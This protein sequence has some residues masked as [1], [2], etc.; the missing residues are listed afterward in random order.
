MTGIRMAKVIIDLGNS[1]RPNWR[2]VTAIV[3]NPDGSKDLSYSIYDTHA[4]NEDS[5]KECREVHPQFSI[6]TETVQ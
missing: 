2:Y 4:L 1:D 6:Q 3:T 5:L